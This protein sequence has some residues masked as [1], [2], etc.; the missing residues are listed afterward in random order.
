MASKT[1]RSSKTKQPVD[2]SLLPDWAQI[3]LP[4]VLRLYPVS[5][6]HW[7]DGISKGIYPPGKKAGKRIRTWTVEEIRNISNNEAQG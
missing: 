7:W 1:K 4:D 3:R 6:S 5:P 2:L